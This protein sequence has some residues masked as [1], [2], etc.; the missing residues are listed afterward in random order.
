MRS[1]RVFYRQDEGW[2]Y[3]YAGKEPK[4]PYDSPLQAGV[5]AQADI[6]TEYEGTIDDAHP[7]DDSC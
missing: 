2:F 4:G 5:A 1:V 6:L 3:Q 7:R